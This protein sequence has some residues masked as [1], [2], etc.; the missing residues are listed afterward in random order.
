MYARAFPLPIVYYCYSFF[1]FFMDLMNT[2]VCDIGCSFLSLCG[3]YLLILYMVVC[4]MQVFFIFMYMNLSICYD[5]WLLCHSFT[6]SPPPCSIF[7]PS[8]HS[9]LPDTVL[10]SVS[11]L[12]ACLPTRQMFIECKTHRQRHSAPMLSAAYPVPTVKPGAETFCKN[13]Y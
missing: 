7:P 5:F 8:E 12:M 9:P 4:A 11:L 13:D 6:L 10:S 3:I 2:C 1:I